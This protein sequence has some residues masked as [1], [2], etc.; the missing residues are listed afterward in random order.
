[1]T[2]QS[3]DITFTAT[4]QLKAD[5]EAIAGSLAVAV[6]S[7]LAVAVGTAIANNDLEDDVEAAGD[8]STLTAAGNITIQASTSKVTSTTTAVAAALGVATGAAGVGDSAA[9]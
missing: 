5:A 4:D 2:N 6:G 3:G 8:D 1:T 9:N 7:G